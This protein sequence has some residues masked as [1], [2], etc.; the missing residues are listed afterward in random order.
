[1]SLAFLPLA[2]ALVLS[3]GQFPPSSPPDSI[4]RLVDMF[5][6]PRVAQGVTCR[7]FASTDPSGHGDDHGHFLRIEGKRAVLAECDGPGVIARLWSAN[8]AGQLRV[9]LDGES[10]PRIDCPFPDLFTGKYP[11][12]VEPIATHQGGGWISYFPIPFAKSCRVEVDDLADPGALYYQVQVL[13]YPKGTA[14]RTFTRELPANEKTALD[15]VLALWRSPGANPTP[16]S[17][18]DGRVELSAKI[19]SEGALELPAISG[20]G[21]VVELRVE[22]KLTRPETIRQLKLV[23]EF[24]GGPGQS[25]LAPVGDF[26][27]VGFGAKTYHGLALGWDGGGYCYF[28]MPFR[29]EARLRLVNLSD[30]EIEARLVAVV[31]QLA[32][33]PDD[34]GTFH[35]EFRAVDTVGEDL[36][37]FASAT[38]PGKWVGV[39]AT[40]QGVGDLWY[41]EGNEEFTID[42]EPKPSIVGTGTEDFFNGGWYW[43]SGP[44]ALPLNGLGV[45]EEWTTNRTT[46][47][48]IQVPDA[49]PFA[50]S[51]VAR[52]E[53][54]SSNQVLDASYSSVAFWYGPTTPVMKMSN[55]NYR[56]PRI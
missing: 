56:I 2:A 48:R 9:F 7:Q 31:R 11:P 43:D 28:P 47:Y 21:V 22:P 13:R 34:V 1:M 8:A 36:Y 44:L 15:R 52:I 4:A 41:L 54:G 42:G 35:A 10:T 12:F 49:V 45:K 27:G 51:L 5:A 16:P 37:E 29:R 17:P 18:D 20:P 23:A 39:N 33:I 19:P 14:M 46:P 32:A 6:L 40:L 3:P 50:K 38:G 24:D 25:V 26:F 55:A 30:S 53:H